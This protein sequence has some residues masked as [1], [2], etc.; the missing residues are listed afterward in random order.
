MFVVITAIY[1]NDLNNLMTSVKQFKW[2]RL[3]CVLNIDRFS[4]ISND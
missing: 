1:T 3:F 4:F 2:Y